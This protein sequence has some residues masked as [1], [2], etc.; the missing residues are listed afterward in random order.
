M[1]NNG[2]GFRPQNGP[3]SNY[4]QFQNG[5]RNA[6]SSPVGTAQPP[7]FFPQQGNPNSTMGLDG[8]SVPLTPPVGPL[9]RPMTGPNRMA[10]TALSNPMS[11]NRSNESTN[12]LFKDK[13]V[14]LAAV[15]IS[16]II[17]VGLVIVGVRGLTG[18]QADVTLYQANVK[19]V[20]QDIG[21]GGIVFPQQQLDISYP[22][23]TRVVQVPVKAGDQVAVGQSLLQL[24]PTQIN[25]QVKQASDELAAAQAFLNSVSAGG[26]AVQIADAQK[27]FDVAKSRYDAL[28]AQSSSPLLHNGN[29]ISPMNGVVTAINI[30]AG[31]VFNANTPLMTIMD[32]S[33]EIVHVKVPLTNLQQVH[34]GQTATVTPSALPNINLSGTV[35]S[36]VPVADPQTDTFEAWVQVK[37]TDKVLLPGMSAFVRIQTKPQASIVVPRMAV[38]NPH[39]DSVVFVVRNQHAYLQHVHIAG[40]SPESVYVDAGLSKG[41]EI[42]LIG[43]HNLKDGQAVRVVKTE[44][45]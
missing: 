22:S 28:V 31:E 12:G 42:V 23:S 40:R 27:Q 15:L 35:V 1:G 8:R 20:N 6:P 43:M 39:L 11:P 24:D 44:S 2:S 7:P 34:L 13:R 36:I 21:G 19:D 4:E 33:S 26:N 38:L 29:I 3:P 10:Q 5:M 9:P 30:N 41:D 45:V 18:G 14:M 25:L 16:G 32:E 17:I 37:N